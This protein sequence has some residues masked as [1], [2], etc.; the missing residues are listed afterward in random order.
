VTSVTTDATCTADGKIVYTATATFESTEYTDTKEVT[1]P[2]LGHDYALSEWIWA[3]DLSSASAKFVCSHDA[4]HTETV[5]ATV[6][7]VTI[8]ATCTE[9][10]KIVYT[11]T[12]TFESEEY[13][14]TVEVVIPAHGHEFEN[15]VCVHCGMLQEI[16]GIYVAENPDKT[17]YILSEEVDWTG[18]VVM[19]I[20]EDSSIAEIP[21]EKLII[22]EVNPT[23]A[24]IVAVT[25]QYE[26]FDAG[27]DIEFI[28]KPAIKVYSQGMTIRIKYAPNNAKYE[29]FYVKGQVC[30]VGRI[31]IAHDDQQT[32]IPVQVRGLYHV[33]IEGQTYKVV[34]K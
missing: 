30:D 22:D 21:F 13:V 31:K 20:Y 28:E 1:L 24:G 34:V 12:V 7:S 18:L 11:A 25:L 5:A 3:D 33:T 15:H 2:A 32:V 26:D 23:E 19:A 6:T 16:I 9:D 17:K 8:D 27:V 14:D 29:V 10:G 4:S